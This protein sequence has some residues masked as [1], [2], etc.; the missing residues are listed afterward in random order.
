MGA[1]EYLSIGLAVAAIVTRVAMFLRMTQ[2]HAQAA[3]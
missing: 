1:V 2:V 3:A